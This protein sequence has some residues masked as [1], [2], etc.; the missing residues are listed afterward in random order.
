MKTFYVLWTYIANHSE[1]IYQVQAETAE[2]ARDFILE[3][4]SDD[5][6]QKGRVYVFDQLPVATHNTKEPLSF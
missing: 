1:R 4:Y 2:K 3:V 5:F 6:K